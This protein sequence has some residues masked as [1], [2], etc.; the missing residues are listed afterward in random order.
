V[1]GNDEEQE[2]QERHQGPG[3]HIGQIQCCLVIEDLARRARVLLGCRVVLGEQPQTVQAEQAQEQ[4]LDE[5]GS[6]AV[7]PVP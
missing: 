4:H 2:H 1:P 5:E 7:R 3:A 6:P